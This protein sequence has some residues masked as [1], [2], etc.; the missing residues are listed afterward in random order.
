M[1]KLTAT[2]VELLV[3]AFINETADGFKTAE[4][5]ADSLAALE[6][7]ED[8]LPE[9]EGVVNREMERMDEDDDSDRT[10]YR[11]LWLLADRIADTYSQ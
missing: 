5:L 11:A 2:D 10:I 4:L 3:T 1:L 6:V 7:G 9:L 8:L